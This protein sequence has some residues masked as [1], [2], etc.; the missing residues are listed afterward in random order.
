M[1][2]IIDKV[3]KLAKKRKQNPD[4]IAKLLQ[5]KDVSTIIAAMKALGREGGEEGLSCLARLVSCEDA[6]IRMA[7]A[8]GLG[9]SR[10]DIAFAHLSHLVSKE[11]DERVIR[12]AKEAIAKIRKNKDLWQRDF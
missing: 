8:E 2:N 4:K 10:C 1:G 11:K 6:Q 5:Y 9:E 7:A 12:A 3:I